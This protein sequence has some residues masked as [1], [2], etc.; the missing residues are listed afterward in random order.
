M[1]FV[2]PPNGKKH[3]YIFAQIHSNGKLIV[4]IL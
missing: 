3:Q 4:E 1:L 2:A